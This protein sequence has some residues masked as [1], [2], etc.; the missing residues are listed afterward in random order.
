MI[1]LP[2]AEELE[3]FN[4]PIIQNSLW[5]ATQET[6]LMV[7]WAS[8][9][10]VIIGLPLGMAIVATS[11]DGIRPN[12]IVNWILSLIVNVGRS[13][14]FIIL[15]ILLLP[16]TDFVMRTKIGWQG[17]VFPLAIG[18]IPFYAR[19]VETNLRSV[20]SGKVE[21]A[22]MMGA[23]RT[24]IMADVLLREALPGIIQ[25]TAVLI[26]LIVGYSAMGGTVGGGGLGAL[27]YNYGYQ[28]YFLDVLVITV[29][30]L[31]IIVQ[32]VQMIGDMLSRY[33]DHR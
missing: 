28:R 29:V 5:D 3:W 30:L 11:K 31:I 32:L 26:I 2:R 17:M 20:D 21:A 25:S 9:A 1:P 4:N 13:I 16:V 6:L 10:T 14:P 24:R 27:A 33:V 15:L 12:R 8:L 19:L 23:S 22:Q 18:S 7:G